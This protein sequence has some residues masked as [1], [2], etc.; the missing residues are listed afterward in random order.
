MQIRLR[1]QRPQLTTSGRTCRISQHDNNHKSKANKRL[2]SRHRK[3]GKT[4]HFATLMNLCHIRNSEWDNKFQKYKGRV[5]LRGD[6]LKADAD[7]YVVFTEQGSSASHIAA[8][9]LDV[10]SRLP[11]CA[12][13]ASNAVIRLHLSKNG[14]RSKVILITRIRVPNHL[15]SSTKIPPVVPLERHVSGDPLAGLL[16]ERQFEKVSIENG[17]GN[18]PNLEC[19][20]MHREKGLF[21]NVKVDEIK[22][23]G[24]KNNLNPCGANWWNKWILRN[25]LLC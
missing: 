9:V 25:Q 1:M 11:G 3:E 16:W 12:G 7:S 10:I 8:K 6:V 24:K 23:V 20:F 17:W 13:Q 14:R 4:V 5:A 19:S 2:L 22:K 21:L 18:V 15:G